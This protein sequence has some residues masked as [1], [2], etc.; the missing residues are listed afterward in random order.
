MRV[1]V[2]IPTLNAEAYLVPLMNSLIAQTVDPEILVIDSCSQDA[3]ASIV[4]RYGER[5]RLL[6]IPQ[7]SFDHGGTRDF[8]LRQTNGEFVC[9]LT[10][11][12]LPCAENSVERLLAAFQDPAVA[13]AFGRQI[14]RSDAPAYERL[15]REFNYPPKSRVVREQDIASLGV[16][17]YF[18]SNAFSAYRRNAYEAMGG[19]DAPIVS[20]EDMLLAAKLLHAGHALAYVADAM[21][22]H[23]HRLSLREEFLRYQASGYAMRQHESRLAGAANTSAEGLRMARQ[24]CRG[25][26]DGADAQQVPVFLAH[27]AIRFAGNRIGRMQ[28][29][30]DERV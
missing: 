19:F 15:T 30:R 23:S 13:A 12:C 24:V 18:F 26:V 27:T 20:N 22:Y 25:L 29:R 9:F 28:A 11:D 21:A 6:Q 7:S 8:A 16:K 1:S 5:V 14:A 2:I 4:Q 17:A 10:Q 3:T